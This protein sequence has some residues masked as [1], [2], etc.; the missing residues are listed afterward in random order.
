MPTLVSAALMPI[1]IKSE[2]G[3]RLRDTEALL[4]QLVLQQPTGTA[5]CDIDTQAGKACTQ[6]AKSGHKPPRQVVAAVGYT[7]WPSAALRVL[8]AHLDLHK[9]AAQPELP[10]A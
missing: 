3:T 4:Q 2:L 10:P 6:Q 9:A 8:S 5:V 7:A 1:S